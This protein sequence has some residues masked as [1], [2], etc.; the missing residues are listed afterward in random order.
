MKQIIYIIVIFNLQSIIFSEYS[1]QSIAQI[2][3]PNVPSYT[4][5]LSFDPNASWI[6][7]DT[8]RNDVCCGAT[9]V[10][11]IEFIITLHPDAEGIILD[12]YSGAVPGGALFYQ[13]NC[14]TPSALGDPIC[15]I[16]TGPHVVTF[17]K[18][19]QNTNEYSITAISD[20]G[21]SDA[22]V[23]NDQCSGKLYTF[24]YDPSSLTWT[25]INPDTTGAYDS[26]LSCTTGCDTTYV[27]AQ[28]GFP[29]FVDYQVC[30]LPLGGCDTIFTC[31]TVRVTFNSTLSVN[32][33][34]GNAT[35]CT[36]SPGITLT[37]NSFGGTPPFSYSW[38]TGD[39]TQSI[40]VGA[41]TYIV[42][43]SDTS[44]CPPAADTVTVIDSAV[45]VLSTNS[46]D[47]ACGASNGT[48]SVSVSGSTP[49]YTYLWNDPLA[50]TDS[51]ATG[52]VPGVYTVTVTDPSGCSDSAIVIINSPGDFSASIAGSSNVLCFGDNNGV[53]TVNLTG[54]PYSPTYSWNTIPVQTTPFA[55]G[56]A[57]GVYIL[58]ITD[59]NACQSFAIVTI[60][61]PPALVLTT[62][63]V[64]ASCSASDG[65]A[66]VSVAGGS[67]AYTYSWL[68]VGGTGATATGL[69]VGT[70]TVTVTDSN[71]CDTA[72][73]V[74]V[75]QTI[76]SPS[77][78][79]STDVS[80]N[81]ESNGG[82]TATVVGG[83]PP[84]TYSWSPSGGT[85]AT[86]TG[87]SP[88]IYTVTVTDNNGCDSTASITIT[89][90]DTLTANITS[91]T[92]VSC[93]GGN[94]GD[95]TV[96]AGGGI[97]PYTYSWSPSGGT[98]AIA[99]GLAAGTTYTVTVTDANGC[100][101]TASVSI[102]EPPPLNASIT[103]ST[104]ASCNGVCD[105][106]A[107]AASTGGTPPY[108]YLWCNGETGSTATGL[109]SGTCTVTVTD[110]NG[111]PNTPS[112]TI[113]EPL[114][115]TLVLSST[116]ATC[117]S[118]D[119]AVSVTASNGVA[120]YT[121]SWSNGANTKDVSG[122][123]AGSYTVIVTD[124]SGCDNTESVVITMGECV[125]SIPTAFTPNGNGINDTWV[126]ENID[127]Y[128]DCIVKVFNRWG[129]IV[130]SS[131]GY[132]TQWNGKYLGIKLPTAV[133]YYVIENIDGALFAE[134][135]KPYGWVT[136]VK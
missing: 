85:G 10:R 5:D 44:L 18:P 19:G 56:L 4:V 41:G 30:G 11:C 38:N 34:P 50:Q 37:A 24:G 31:D 3:G 59:S 36:G 72:T 15:L 16:G 21:V 17:C 136:I 69:A 100:D 27:S 98:G 39:T 51:V 127:Q 133:Y 35:I 63:S 77:I 52:L 57:G 22:I 73:N 43:V 104:D 9:G 130:F 46:L 103:A 68:P 122:L 97:S 13:V 80:C 75:T 87:L 110:S 25:S 126:I 6:S 28:P 48:A 83:T 64:E 70:Y 115:I 54:F 79:T 12:I 76:M 118:T 42:T 49:P 123:S 95:A 32:I 14:S 65:E 45:L 84:Y 102:T 62:G 128:P 120:P 93:N 111:C 67:G 2:C 71:G 125:I 61:E 134:G 105:G 88:G 119:G 113:T 82:A 117:K 74:T 96:T 20:P 116:D 129:D 132:E 55:T 109:C 26:Y 131:K 66:S 78:F 94:D 1:G 106:S 114:P 107:I 89:E 90:P 99:T 135:S 112:V 121:Y 58:Q 47:A 33:S 60:T 23:I 29:Q 124:A 81:G 92:D 86:A 101:T 91:S 40:F 53:A 108:T 8:V 7:P